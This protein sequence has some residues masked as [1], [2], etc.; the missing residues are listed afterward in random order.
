MGHDRVPDPDAGTWTK[1][2]VHS[3]RQNTNCAILDTPGADM[4]VY[5]GRK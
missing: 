4:Q 2:V 3:M 5:N 1:D